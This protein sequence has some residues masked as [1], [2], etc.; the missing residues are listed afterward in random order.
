[1]NKGQLPAVVSMVRAGRLAVRMRWLSVSSVS[2]EALS[3]P[4]DWGEGRGRSTR[5]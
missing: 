3:E 5:C 4:G 2:E 1:M